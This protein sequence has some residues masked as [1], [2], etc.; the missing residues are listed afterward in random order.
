MFGRP[1]RRCVQTV[2][3]TS[4]GSEMHYGVM[5]RPA[6]VRN[7]CAPGAD[8]RAAGGQVA[9]VTTWSG[10]PPLAV[11]KDADRRSGC[12]GVTAGGTPESGCRHA[13]NGC[14][15]GEFEAV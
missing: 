15:S 7:R 10:G 13:E 9:T 14:F 11:G 1:R 8:G 2:G 12:D 4:S 3:R 5:H 6:L